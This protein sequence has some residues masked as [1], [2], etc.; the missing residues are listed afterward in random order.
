MKKTI[1]FIYEKYNEFDIELS[2]K[3]IDD[4]INSH[5]YNQLI[6]K[7]EKSII[8][9]SSNNPNNIEIK[10]HYIIDY[11]AI[12]DNTPTCGYI[13]IDI[14]SINLNSD[15]LNNIS[16]LL[17][18]DKNQNLNVQYFT[19]NNTKTLIPNMV[20]FI[21]ENENNDV[22]ENWFLCEYDQIKYI[23]VHLQTKLILKPFKYLK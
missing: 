14:A 23:N 21:K 6:T 5:Q 19:S 17:Y 3:S 11:Y 10:G 22:Q 2:E 7:S 18:L 15:D 12:D 13:Y 9:I 20:S 8:N 4:L 1:T 16:F